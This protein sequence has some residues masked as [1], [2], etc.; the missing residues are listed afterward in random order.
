MLCELL[1]RYQHFGE[2]S[3]GS[4]DEGSM[5][6]HNNGMYLQVH[7]ALRPRR[8]TLTCTAAVHGILVSTY[9]TN[10]NKMW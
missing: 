6:L 8:R 2:I 9:S 4:E 3:S 1:G 7:M 10:V 5:F